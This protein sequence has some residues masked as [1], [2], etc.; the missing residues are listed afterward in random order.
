[1]MI[2]GMEGVTGET[3]SAASWCHRAPPE[4]KKGG[5]TSMAWEFEDLFNNTRTDDGGFLAEPYFLP[6][7]QM[8][9]KRRTTVSGP[10]IDAEVFPV[11]GRGVK[12]MLRKARTGNGTPD[13]QKKANRD[14]S[15]LRA[16]QIVEANFGERDVALALT[17]NGEAPTPDR[18]DKDLRNF[19]DRVKRR[20]KNLGLPELKYWAV[21]GGDEMPAAGYSGKRPHIHVF[22]NG[23]ISRDELELMWGKGF[24]NVDRLQPGSEGLAAIATY[25]AKQIKDRKE[26]PG[27]RRWRASKNLVKPVPRSRPAK[28]PNARVKKIAFG[29]K[30]EAKEIMEKLYPGYVMTEEPFIRFSDYVPGVYIRCVLR[31]IKGGGGI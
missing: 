25:F 30:N 17:Y 27:A 2:T 21:I 20:R 14:R 23:G 19:T 29:F 7:G 26:K 15:I 31:K 13:A 6:V 1:M 22:M 28:M 16:I 3:A 5:G 11:F 24:A 9:Y 8:G 10:R 18:V 12:T 4:A